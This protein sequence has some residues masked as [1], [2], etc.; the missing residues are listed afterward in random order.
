MPLSVAKKFAHGASGVRRDVL[1]RSRLRGRG[2]DHDGVVHRPGVGEGLHHLCDRR[3]LLP[4]TA[5]NAN[6][7]AALL[8]DDGVQNDGGLTGLTVSDDELALSAADRDHRI[9]CFD[10]GLQ[11]LANW[12]AVQH[13]RR[14][15]LE[16]IALLRG[17]GTL[18][19]K[20]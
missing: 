5:I 13:A 11:R 9:D 4:D 1:Q 14:D 8:I 17:D 18:A 10:T 15:L 12:L 19:T 6:D 3:A 20:Q 2:G 7:V 16:W